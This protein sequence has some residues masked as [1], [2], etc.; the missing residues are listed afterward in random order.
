MSDWAAVAKRLADVAPML[1]TVV[2]G[3]AGGAIGA[4]IASTLGTNNDPKAVLAKL[5]TDP[6]A[7]VKIQQLENEERDS[8]RKHALGMATVELADVQQ[9]R[10][11]HKDHWMPAL[12]TILLTFMI[13]SVTYG[14]MT[15]VV[16]PDSKEVLFFLVGQLTGAFMTAI[17]FWLGSSRSSAVKTKMMGGSTWPQ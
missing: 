12:L 2:G 8:L 9:A 10:S 14:L 16:P 4:V 13:A 3:P 7:M 5:S 15:L 6:E 17:T 1:G 11:T